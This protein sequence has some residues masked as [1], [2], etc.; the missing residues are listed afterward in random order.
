MKNLFYSRLSIRYILL[1]LLYEVLSTIT[2]KVIVIM[3]LGNLVFFFFSNIDYVLKRIKNISVEKNS[4]KVRKINM[5]HWSMLP[6]EN[7][8]YCIC[9]YF[10]ETPKIIR[11]QYNRWEVPVFKVNFNAVTHLKLKGND[12]S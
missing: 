8:V 10:T 1:V 7:T 3:T 12:R 5:F 9:R 2:L 4:L 11:L 6:I